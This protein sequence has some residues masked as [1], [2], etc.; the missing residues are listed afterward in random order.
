MAC[1]ARCISLQLSAT[2]QIRTLKAKSP[3][4]SPGNATKINNLHDPVREPVLQMVTLWIPCT[5]STE[6]ALWIAIIAYDI[7]PRPRIQPL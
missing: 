6:V 5:A 1:E 3:G 2:A 7:H 4:S